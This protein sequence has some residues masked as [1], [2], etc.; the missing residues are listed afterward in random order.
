MGLH[1][2]YELDLARDLSLADV[3]ERVRELHRTAVT[4]PFDMVGPLVQIKEGE[5][6]DNESD[7][8]SG[9]A[10]F[11]RFCAQS[12]LDPRDPVTD[13]RIDVLPNAV[14]FA[15]NAG[16]G[17]ETATFGVAWVPPSD[18]DGN[19]LRGEPYIWHWHGV[20]K[21]QYASVLGDDHLI[22]CHTSLVALLDKAAELGFDVT[23]RDETHYWE[24]RDT[25]V[26]LSEVREM[27]RIVA[28]FAGNFHDALREHG[29][30]GGAIFDHPDFE[31]LETRDGPD[32]RGQRLDD[33]RSGGTSP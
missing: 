21:T 31:E 23:V 30:V 1:L 27:N 29:H 12:R 22:R 17:C 19:R 25:N 2:C 32:E 13:A 7:S 8:D 16:E 6:L 18:E 26:L 28:H 4:L 3:T 24:T 5:S 11:I 10:S 15:V 20:P 33:S 14:G 9:L